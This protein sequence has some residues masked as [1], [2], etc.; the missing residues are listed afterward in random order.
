MSRAAH[1]TPQEHHLSTIGHL[2][3]RRRKDLDLTQEEVGR[4]AGLNPTQVSR[5]ESG[6]GNPNVAT[7]A[8]AMEGLGLT[9]E[10]LAGAGRVGDLVGRVGRVGRGGRGRPAN[11][12]D[13]EK[14]EEIDD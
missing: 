14:Y 5:L 3:R 4:R 10:D 8:R 9:L 1:P 12:I 13:Y 7:L 11:A 6:E 2:L